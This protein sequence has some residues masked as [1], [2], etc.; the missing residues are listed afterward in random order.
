MSVRVTNI[1]CTCNF[2]TSIY[3]PKFIVEYPFCEWNRKKF[4]AATIRFS[5]PKSTCLLFGSGR[6]V[7]TGARTLNAARVTILQAC[8]LVRCAGYSPKVSDFKVQNI[9]SSF[10]FSSSINLDQLFNKYP[11]ETNYEPEL[12]P[13]LIFRPSIQNNGVYLIFESGRV[14][15][16][17]CKSMESVHENYENATNIIKSVF[18]RPRPKPKPKSS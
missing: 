13:A 18:K 3:L 14:V 10:E 12:F 16:T 8:H 1:V 2:N 4:A 15:I 11:E 7:C 17:G 5:D 6:I 9:A